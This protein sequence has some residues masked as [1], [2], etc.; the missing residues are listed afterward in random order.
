MPAGLTYEPIATNTL[1][2]ATKSVTFSSITGTYTDLVLIINGKTTGNDDFINLRFNSD[3]GSNYSVTRFY[4]NGT[5]TGS[6]RSSNQSRIF[7]G[8]DAAINTTYQWNGILNFMN[9]SNSTTY[10]TVLFRDNSPSGTGYPGT[11]ANVGL[12]R[13]T[14]A[15][16]AIEVEAN[17]Y[18]F[19]TGSTFT[20]YG[21]KSA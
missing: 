13:N 8:Y 6:G 5:T 2:T 17:T 18:N 9:Y 21:I 11:A 19:D 20:L 12:W 16:T 3:T 7:V 14:N 10:K 15:I 4:G 1:S